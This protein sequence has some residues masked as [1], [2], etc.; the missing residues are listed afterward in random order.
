MKI[1]LVTE[2]YWPEVGAA[3]SR[4][5]NLAEGLKECGCEVD[6]LTAL[7][8]YPQGRI[9]DGYRGK[10]YKSEEHKGVNLFRYWIYATVSSNPLSRIINMFSFGI[11]IWL[12]ALRFK[13]IKEYS[14][15]IIQTPTLV[16]ASSAMFLFK[17]IFHKKCILNISDIWP[18]T[19]VDMGV[20]QQSSWSYRFMSC[21]ERFLYKNADGIMGQSEEIL[22][23][24]EWKVNNSKESS[25]TLD[26]WE[27]KIWKKNRKL[28]LYRNLQR[29]NIEIKCKERKEPLKFV[30]SGLLGV[31]Q[32]VYGL[33]ENI[34]WKTLNVEFH[35]I[36]G[37]KQME[38]INRFISEHP[39]CNVFVHGFVPKEEIPERLRDMNVSIVPLVTRI[40]GAFPSKIFDLLPQG[41]PVLFCGEGEG[42]TF[43]KE[44][45]VGYASVPGDYMSLIDNI[46]IMISMS[47]EEYNKMSNRCIKVSQEELDFNKQMHDCYNWFMCL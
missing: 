21:L 15:I 38:E 28:F 46:K 43:I 32:N 8:N 39:D 22:N 40:R 37:G 36:G 11:V 45:E 42:A 6:V 17:K 3:P 2:K 12:F 9:F 10:L 24:V 29:Y 18:L 23:Y 30:Y 35:I 44:N 5:E 27:S 25:P 1:L 20:M 33:V 26:I 14:Y 19:A 41:I 31:A 7:P 34:P 47:D 4:L 13:L 16:A